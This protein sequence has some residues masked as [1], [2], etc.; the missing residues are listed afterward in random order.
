MFGVRTELN[1]SIVMRQL[2][3]T[4]GSTESGMD[5]PLPAG[6]FNTRRRVGGVKSP[7]GAGAEC[8]EENDKPRGVRL[9]S[10]YVVH[11]TKRC[12]DLAQGS[13][14][15]NKRLP[16]SGTVAVSDQKKCDQNFVRRTS[17]KESG[18][19]SE[20]RRTWGRFKAATEAG[21]LWGLQ[22]ETL[23][24]TQAGRI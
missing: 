14:I 5:W 13:D 4:G 9:V 15:R 19:R 11:S 12:F 23:Q 1:H 24:Q 3:Q 22:A 10:S 18:P 16:S 8:W 7:G 2:P 21:A 20:L 6:K 17:D